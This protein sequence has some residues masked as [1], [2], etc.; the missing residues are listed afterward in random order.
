MDARGTVKLLS[1][2]Q[3]KRPRKLLLTAEGQGQH[4]YNHMNCLALIDLICEIVEKNN[5][6]STLKQGLPA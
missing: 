4:Q 1:R 3:G 2:D 6:K 5:I